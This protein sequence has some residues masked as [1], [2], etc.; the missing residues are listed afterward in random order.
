MAI[1]RLSAGERKRLSIFF[2][3]IVMA[4][5]AWMFF[6]LSQ[7]Y[8]YKIK[9]LV[10]FKN[11]PINKA[12]YPLQSDTVTLNVRGIGWQLLFNKISTSVG[13]I[14]VDL[15]PLEKRNFI[16]FNNQIRD[17]NQQF[18]SN[19]KIISVQPDTLFFD[20]TTRKVKR[21]PIRFVSDIKY[22]KQFGQNKPV[23]LKPAFVT[24]TGPTELLQ[25]IEYWETDTLKGKNIEKPISSKVLLKSSLEANISIFPT[26]IEV[27]LPVEEHTEKVLHI[28]IKVANNTDYYNVKMIPNMV[29]ATVLV[30][31][32]DY[33]KVSEDNITASADFSLWKAGANKLPVTLKNQN[34]FVKIQQISPQQVDYMIIK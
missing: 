30:S 2:T 9:T 19:Q 7:K 15:T 16:S 20:F 31:L 22:K 13:E 3:C 8:D 29:T 1:I 14:K 34:P 33:A 6:S 23:E 4:F 26:V 10:T 12:F 17:I 32:S 28:P 5:V 27:F 21:V 24:L 18:S 11:L 25:K